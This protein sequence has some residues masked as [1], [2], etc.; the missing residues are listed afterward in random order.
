VLQTARLLHPRRRVLCRQLPLVIVCVFTSACAGSSP[1]SPSPADSSLEF[2]F[3]GETVSAIDGT[4]LGRVAIKIGSQ[5]AQSDE[6]GRFDVRNLREGS[7]TIVISGGSIVERQRTVTI[8]ASELS[9]ESLI[10]ASFDLG[11]FDE[12]LRGDGRLQ[13][14]TS[15]P[16]LVVLGKEM[17]FD[18]S[19]S[20]DTYHATSE[21]LTEAD[22]SLL[23]A[24]LTEGLALLT[25][26]TFTAFSSITIESPPSG[27]RVTTLRTGSIVVGRYRGVQTLASTIGFGRW[28]NGDAFEVIGGVIFLDRNYD[29][30][31][32]QRRLLRIHELGHALGYRHVKTRASIMNPA[33]GPEPTEFDRQAAAIAFQRMPGNRAPDN[34]VA[35]ATPRSPGGGIFGVRSLSRPTWSPPIIC[36][37]Q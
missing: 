31:S 17:Q 8:P 18:N 14:W 25:G 26:N 7:D 29:E 20:D 24:H 27:A 4:P 22:I 5:T 13:R 2:A 34:D 37:L 35:E 36:G 6:N 10:P 9:R 30:S 15:A 23:I 33:I 3:R 21:A 11:A 12:M 1:S 28:E 16:A 32:E 19:A